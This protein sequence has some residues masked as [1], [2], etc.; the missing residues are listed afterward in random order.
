MEPYDRYRI[1]ELRD[2]VKLLAKPED[3]VKALRDAASE[4]FKEALMD[5]LLEAA[6]REA[7]EQTDEHVR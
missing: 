7:R 4:E 1:I 2:D 5:E 3:P 6:H